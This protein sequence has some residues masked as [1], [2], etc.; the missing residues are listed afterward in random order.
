MPLKWRA[1]GMIS[2]SFMPPLTTMLTLTGPSPACVRRVDAAQHVGDREVDVV[3]AAESGVVHCVERHRDPVQ[4]GVLQRLRL[5]RQQRAVRGQGQVEFAAVRRAQCAQHGDQVFEVL[6][7]QRFAAGQADLLH[8]VGDEKPR[9]AGDFLEGQQRAM[10]QVGV[11]LVEHFLRHAIDAAEIAAVGDGNAQVVQRAREGIGQQAV[12]A[13]QHGRDG[14]RGLQAAVIGNRYDF[15]WMTWRG[16]Y[17][18]MAGE[19]RGA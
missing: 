2:S 9:H 19:I 1:I 8:A 17:Q 11:I 13:F 16:V 7:Q 6:A 10:R 12:R 14:G 3:H 15:V 4:P 5:A 18:G